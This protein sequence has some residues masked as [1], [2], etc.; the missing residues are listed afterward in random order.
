MERA[1]YLELGVEV[2]VKGTALDDIYDPSV[3]KELLEAARTELAVGSRVEHPGVARIRGLLVEEGRDALL[4]EE[5]VEGPTLRARM[6]EEG[7]RTA[8]E[9]YAWPRVAAKLEAYYADLLAGEQLVWASAKSSL[10]S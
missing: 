9:N 2:A 5:F 8:L 4:I 3:R 10:A 7:R 1:Y 6:G